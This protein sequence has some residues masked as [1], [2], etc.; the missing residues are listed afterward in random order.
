MSE[1]VKSVLSWI[2]CAVLVG[3]ALCIGFARDW[4]KQR[5][6]VLNALAEDSALV[7]Q[8]QNRAM[9]AANLAVV[10]ARHLDQEDAALGVLR[11]SSTLLLSGETKPEVLLAADEGLTRAA[12]S[13]RETLL[14]RPSV[15]ASARDQA[16][17]STLTRTLSEGADI[18]S[19]YRTLVE[20]FNQRLNNSVTGAIAR[21]LGVQPL[22]ILQPA[23]PQ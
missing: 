15:Q 8:L 5:T 14:P 12:A 6:E 9:D 17:I 21:L 4:Q 7:E 19:A 1:K 11:E 3:C 20:D 10:V 2:L 13:L 18:A 23:I 22:S 16:Y